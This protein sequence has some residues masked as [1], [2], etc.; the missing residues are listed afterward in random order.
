MVG[1]SPISVVPA[2]SPAGALSCADTPHQQEGA[3]QQT[4]C[5]DQTQR[6]GSASIK[7]HSINLT[8]SVLTAAPPPQR[9]CAVCL[10]GV[11]LPSVEHS[12]RSFIICLTH[13]HFGGWT[14]TELRLY[15]QR[16]THR[17]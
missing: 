3:S 6:L 8:Q 9:V 15:P 2:C 13:E 10:Y 1:L 4:L 7:L 14:S 17:N 11:H 12:K 5:T 16:L